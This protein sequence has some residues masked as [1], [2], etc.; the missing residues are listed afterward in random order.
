MKIALVGCGYVADFYMAT[1]RRH[2]ALEVTC[3][4]D[5]NAVRRQAFGAF[6]GVPTYA[7][8]N[9]LLA[10]TDAPLILNLTNPASH[11][12]VS[13]AILDAGRHVY[14]EK[15]LALDFEHARELVDLARS[16]GVL[17]S[18]A[19]CTI[20]SAAAQSAWRAILDGTVGQVRL[21][22][23]AVEDGMVFRKMFNLWR[24]ASG[25]PWPYADEFALGCT[26]QHAGYW[27]MWLLAFFGPAQKM[28][29]HASCLFPDKGLN[30]FQQEMAA[31]FSVA[32]LT[33]KSG[34]VARLTCGVVAP[35]DRSLHI[36]GDRA[37]LTVADAWNNSSAIHLQANG[38]EARQLSLRARNKAKQLMV[39]GIQRF[40]PGAFWGG[41]RLPV[42]AG[43]E[44]APGQQHNMDFLSG[45]MDQA[46]AILE[47][48]TPLIA[49]DYLLHA[50]ELTLAI[51]HADR[52]PQ[53]YTPQSAFDHDAFRRNAKVDG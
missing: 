7:T 11:Y 33:F 19:P 35:P 23:A 21:V 43:S 6:H 24:S 28:T 12:E 3:A 51:Q 47:N 25:A 30:G 18:G 49:A 53:P 16:K 13:R 4:C 34:V 15:P 1:L 10:A 29:A 45:V 20:H 8:L 9:E 37:T 42:P 36:V 27:L 32:C 26:I 41:R 31:D 39:N 50:T 40:A 5:P 46:T 38:Q 2:P 52:L 44:K 17:I 48:R 14:T 22:Y